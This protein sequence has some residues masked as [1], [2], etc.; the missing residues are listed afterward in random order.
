M[1]EIKTIEQQR[2]EHALNNI[3]EESGKARKLKEK[4]KSYASALPAN[5]LQNGFGQAMAM[6]L[7]SAKDSKGEE[8]AHKQLYEHI[9]SW[10]CEVN[11]PNSPY[12]NVEHNQ[13]LIIAIIKNDQ[14]TYIQAQTEAMAYLEWLKKFAV[15]F[16]VEK[17]D[18]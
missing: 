2:A 7:A 11:Q 5:I 9:Q 15:A 13:N 8:T 1:N 12:K 3:C 6:E 4:Y 14:K 18:S 10:L 16:L 17:E